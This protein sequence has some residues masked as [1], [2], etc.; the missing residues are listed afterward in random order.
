VGASEKSPA[1][2]FYPKDFLSDEKQIRMSLAAVGIYMRLLCHC[3]N[4]GSL[5]SDAPA[6]ARLSGATTRQLRALWPSI[7]PCFQTTEDGRLVNRRLELERAKQITFRSTQQQRS[8][9]RWRSDQK[10]KAP[11]SLENPPVSDA[12][13]EIRHASGNPNVPQCSSSSSSSSSKYKYTPPANL[14]VSQEIAEKAARFL[15]RYVLVYAEER[16]GAHFALKPVLH[17][18][19]ACELVQGWPDLPRLELMLRTFCKLPASEKMAWPGTPAQF[20]H[21]APSIDAR[22]RQAGV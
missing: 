21:L 10:A 9:A 2:Q 18:Q 14:S 6:L 20:K 4:E 15:E 16:R 12:E 5:P 1:F 7:S 11:K 19:T 22:L 8:A 13:P 17:F 3:W